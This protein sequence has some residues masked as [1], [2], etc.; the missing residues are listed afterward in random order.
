M[1]LMEH[2]ETILCFCKTYCFPDYGF[3]SR[4]S[5]RKHRGW[6]QKPQRF[7][8]ET[9]ISGLICT[10]ITISR[11]NHSNF[12]LEYR[13]ITTRPRTHLFLC[14]GPEIS[15]H[16]ALIPVRKRLFRPLRPCHPV[17]RRRRLCGR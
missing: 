13:P 16:Q 12:C 17:L 3:R 10:G 1:G 8:L 14:T 2:C 9:M 4:C 6:R 15:Y 7:F 5:G 11:K